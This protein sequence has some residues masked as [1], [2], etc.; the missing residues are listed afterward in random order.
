MDPSLDI[1]NAAQTWAI[2]AGIGLYLAKSIF[3]LVK[4]R[5]GE[6][7]LKSAITALASSVT[8]MTQAMREL[9]QAQAEQ[10]ERLL[11][12]DQRT[13]RI[14]SST[15]TAARDTSMVLAIVDRRAN[16]GN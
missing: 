3:E 10:G 1:G 8:A 7:E 16:P 5:P 2:V 4:G 9:R 12:V 6:T 14:E 15:S 13:A 11:T